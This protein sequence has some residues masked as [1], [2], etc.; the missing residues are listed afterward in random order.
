MVALVAGFA[1][2]AA[3]QP[4]PA[5]V[6]LPAVGDPLPLAG[7]VKFD[8]L[9]AVPA[10]ADAAGKVVIHWYCAPTVQTCVDDLAR[11]TTL[12]ENSNRVYVVGYINGA[13]RDAHKLDPI[14]DSEG[15]GRGTLAYGANVTAAFKT[16]GI[17]GPASVVVDVDGKVAWVATGASPETLDARDAKVEALAARIKDYTASA[18]GP[19]VVQANEKFELSMTIKLAGWLVF[20]HK[21][22][23]TM[24]YKVTVSKDIQCDRT[25]LAGDQ[26]KPVNQTLTATVTCSGSKGSYE[27]LGKINFGYDAPTGATGIGTDGARWR[28]EIK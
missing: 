2:V 5:A 14:R 19:K 7:A 16:M 24:E 27:A 4:K 3:G 22:G 23:T 25:A 28:F 6:V 9:Y 17:A 10:I 15:V 26:L 18:G 11:I 21:P 13:K 8:W 1:G 12:K 20:S